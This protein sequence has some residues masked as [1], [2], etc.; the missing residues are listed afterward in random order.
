V[1]E[2]TVVVPASADL[3]ALGTARMAMLGLGFRNLPELPR[4]AEVVEPT[5]SYGPRARSRFAEAV[6]RARSWKQA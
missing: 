3:T 5:G 4:S 1:T 6:S 2:R